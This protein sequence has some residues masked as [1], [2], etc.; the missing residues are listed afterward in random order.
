MNES[1]EDHNFDVFLRH[2]LH[3]SP[4]AEPPPGFARAMAERVA[5][6][7]DTGIVEIYATRVLFSLAVIAAG[8]CA[9]FYLDSVANQMRE[10]LRGAPWPLL[11][12]A[13]VSFGAV[14]L[15]ELAGVSKRDRVER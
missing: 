7:P 10:V 2:A 15:V 11:L 4:G 8:V 9:F 6:L 13:G 12:T 14:K 3:R 5:D 1:R